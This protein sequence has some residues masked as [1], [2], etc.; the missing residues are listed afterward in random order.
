MNKLTALILA[1]ILS[2]SMLSACG[3]AGTGT[4]ASEDGSRDTSGSGSE[5]W[6]GPG[7]N[8]DMEECVHI[9]PP[10][11]FN[12]ETMTVEQIPEFFPVKMFESQLEQGEL[13]PGGAQYYTEHPEHF[14]EF[15]WHK[16]VLLKNGEVVN[17]GYVEEGMKIRIYHYNYWGESLFY[18]EYTV[19]TLSPRSGEKPKIYLSRTITFE[20][21]LVFSPVAFAEKGTEI[22][23]I[24]SELHSIYPPVTDET[25]AEHHSFDYTVTKNGVVVTDGVLEEGMIVRAVY[26]EAYLKDFEKNQGFPVNPESIHDISYKVI[27]I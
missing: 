10:G 4:D 13:Y 21:T 5:G 3:K 12:D 11:G 7:K 26:S 25:G 15:Y 6:K 16:A 19:G 14:N 22:K 24:M 8:P 9:L 20:D 23:D 2:L 17:S 1:I 18:G 27:I